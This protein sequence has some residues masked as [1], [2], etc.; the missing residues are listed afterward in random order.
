MNSIYEEDY[1]LMALRRILKKVDSKLESVF[2]NEVNN[3]KDLYNEVEIHD[4]I[5][6]NKIV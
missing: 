1:Y 4:Y 5:F 3:L 6:Y 2:L